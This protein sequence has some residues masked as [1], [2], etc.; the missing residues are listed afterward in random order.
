MSLIR[1]GVLIL[2]FLMASQIHAEELKLLNWNVKTGSIE[3][4]AKRKRNIAMV[5]EGRTPDILILQEI[6]SFASAQ[7]VADFMGFKRP[8]IA[9]SDFGDDSEIIFFGFETAV[10][11]NI[12]IKS[13]HEYQQPRIKSNGTVIPDP[14]GPIVIEPNGEITIFTNKNVTTLTV[15][16]D[17]ITDPVNASESISR[18]LLRVELENGLV[19][20]PVHFKSNIPRLCNELRELSDGLSAIRYFKNNIPE[21]SIRASKAITAIESL[22]RSKVDGKVNPDPSINSKPTQETLR[23]FAN[24]HAK[25]AASRENAAAALMK[26]VS[27][28]L[29]DT[30]IKGVVV[31]GDFNTPLNEPSKTGQNLSQDC[32]PAKLSCTLKKVE[33]TCIGEDGFD[34][35]HHILQSG[36]VEGTK[37]IPLF[38]NSESTHTGAGF[39]NSPIDNVYVSEQISV[40][41]PARVVRGS[42]EIA[43]GSDHFPIEVYISVD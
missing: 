35:T 7:L 6:N 23:A 43:F 9:V 15:P 10:V 42:D 34:D 30:T 24:G 8:H 1:Y 2:V 29:R 14:N 16:K 38:T 37:L 12:P 18:G 19:I 32:M 36:I 41:R 17:I 11:S 5:P 31:A 39:V 13:V 25:T 20:Y 40:T 33:N 21:V 22:A 27:A 3:Q 26:L 4:I 28:D